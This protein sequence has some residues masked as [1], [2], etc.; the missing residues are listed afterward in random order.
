MLNLK[1]PSTKITLDCSTEIKQP[2]IPSIFHIDQSVYPDLTIT[3]D[4]YTELSSLY[5]TN[6]TDTKL[7]LKISVKGGGCSGLSY[8]MEW[9][10]K[11]EYND[12]LYSF[13]VIQVI[14]E[15]KSLMYLLG[16]TLNYSTGLNGKGFEFINPNATRTCGCGESFT[17]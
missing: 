8:D 10:N 14:I 9:V 3:P 13:G 16:L 11:K 2:L 7:Y 6:N 17:V 12:T 5:K 4:A 1:I 15:P